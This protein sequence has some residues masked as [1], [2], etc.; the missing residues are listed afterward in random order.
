MEAASVNATRSW[1]P[2]IVG[3]LVFYVV[4]PR[5]LLVAYAGWKTFSR[6]STLD[7]TRT[8]DIALI[9]RLSGPLFQTKE[10]S[11]TGYLGE[12]AE[13]TSPTFVENGSWNLRDAEFKAYVSLS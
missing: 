7:F 8:Q 3:N 5:F 1:W 13:I 4:I 6:L 11:R 2:F 12:V 10:S 9:R